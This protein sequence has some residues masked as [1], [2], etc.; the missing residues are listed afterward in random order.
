MEKEYKVVVK[1]GEEVFNIEAE[2]EQDALEFAQQTI[3]EDYNGYLSES[4]E[5]FIEEIKTEETR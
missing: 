5:Y 1:L 3:A 2:S 4:A